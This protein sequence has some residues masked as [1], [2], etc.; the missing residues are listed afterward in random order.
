M[1]PVDELTTVLAG[2]DGLPAGLNLYGAPTDKIEPPAIVIRPNPAW[3]SHGD[4]CRYLERYTAIC[5]VSASSPADG[6]AMLRLLSL[7]IIA[8]LTEPWDWTAVEGPVID[9]TTG[10]PLLANRVQLT[11]ANGGQD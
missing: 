11:Y 1:T 7:A 6:I 4:F 5:V 9:E 10:V 3:I 8:A 2:V